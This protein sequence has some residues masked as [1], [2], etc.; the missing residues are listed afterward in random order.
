MKSTSVKPHMKIEDTDLQNYQKKFKA[1]ADEK[2]LQILSILCS[3]GAS[4]VGDLTERVNLPQSKLSYHLKILLE[5]D[6]IL[7]EQKG[8]WNYYEINNDVLDNL[9]SEELCRKFRPAD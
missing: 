2:R 8:V 5:A 9:L 4:F 1:L 6:I 3:E 7:K